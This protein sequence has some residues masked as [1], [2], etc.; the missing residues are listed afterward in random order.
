[1]EKPFKGL[2]TVCSGN[3][4]VLSLPAQELD[5]CLDL[6]RPVVQGY[7]WWREVLSHLSG[8]MVWNALGG[9]ALAG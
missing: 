7:N 2:V 9:S 8:W 6:F 3:T 1:M 4:D 5:T